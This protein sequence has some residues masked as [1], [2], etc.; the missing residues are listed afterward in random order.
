MDMDKQT[1]GLTEIEKLCNLLM[2]ILQ[3]EE[4]V[5]FELVK[6]E[7]NKKDAILS[8]NSEKL[9]EI[10]KSQETKLELIDKKEDERTILVQKISDITRAQNIDTLSDIA[11][12]NK[13]PEEIKEKLLHHSYSLKELM[14]TL[15]NI[16]KTNMEMLEDNRKFFE[17]IIGELSGEETI[18]YGPGE[19]KQ[20]SSKSI[21]ID[22]TG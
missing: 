14:I 22:Q 21:F 16:S 15:Q 4:D 20:R 10:T 17:T 1:P 8:Q 3:E 6:E 18:G 5:Y 19:T 13:V 2:A 9:I 7:S 12:M 11:E